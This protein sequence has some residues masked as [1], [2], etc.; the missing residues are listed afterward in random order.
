[1]K[2]VFEKFGTSFESRQDSTGIFIDSYIEGFIN[3]VFEKLPGIT[4][5]LSIIYMIYCIV[6]PAITIVK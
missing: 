2:E 4:I 6:A 1:M 3:F 5:G